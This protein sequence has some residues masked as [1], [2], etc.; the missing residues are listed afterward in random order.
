M[1]RLDS[2]LG[3]LTIATRNHRLQHDAMHETQVRF[4]GF[5]TYVGTY[6]VYQRGAQAGARMEVGLLST[7]HLSNIGHPMGQ[8][9]G[10]YAG[11]WKN[12]KF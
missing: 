11:I 3:L 4:T 12:Q 9:H 1:Y 8:Q 2:H 5:E 7:Q 6:G 10:C